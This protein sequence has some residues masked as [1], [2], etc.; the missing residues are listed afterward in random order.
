MLGYK[1]KLKNIY[2]L[3]YLDQLST[4][5]KEKEI[6]RSQKSENDLLQSIERLHFHRYMKI[7]YCAGMNL[8]CR[9]L[10]CQL[11]KWLIFCF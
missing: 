5:E 7:Q 11:V 2:I 9:I 10:I 1:I 4:V 6:L 3:N 8:R